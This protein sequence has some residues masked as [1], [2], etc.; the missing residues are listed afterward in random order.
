M[1]AK[2]SKGKGFRGVLNYAMEKDS[3]ILDSN[4]AGQTPRALAAEFGEVRKLRPSLGNAV[5]HTALSAPVGEQISDDL[6]REIGQTFMEKMGYT[7]NQYIMV[8]HKD[9]DHQHV[10][11]I[12]NRITHTGDVVSDA[13]DYKRLNKAMREIEVEYELTQV[14]SIAA[15]RKAPTK[16]EI[17]RSIRTG[18]PSTRQ[19]LQQLASACAKDCGNYTEYA[20]RLEAVGVE[21]IPYTQMNDTKLNGLMYRLDGV[22]MKGSDLGKAYSPS[23]LAKQGVTYDK[24]RDIAAIQRASEREAHRAAQDQDHRLEKSPTPERGGTGGLDRP[25]GVSP[26]P[27][28]GGGLRVHPAERSEHPAHRAADGNDTEPSPASRG[29]DTESRK[30]HH[31]ESGRDSSRDWT[32]HSASYQRIVRLGRSQPPTRANQSQRAGRSDLSRTSDTERENRTAAQQQ[33]A[34]IK[35]P[36]IAAIPTKKRRGKGYSATVQQ[37]DLKPHW[38]ALQRQN[39]LGAPVQLEIRQSNHIVVENLDAKAIA[40]MTQDGLP[41]LS[42]T[43]KNGS[44]T[45]LIRI[46]DY[47]NVPRQWQTLIGDHIQKTYGG[48]A[49]VEANIPLAGFDGVKL[50]STTD[51]TAPRGLVILK[52]LARQQHEHE[53]AQTLAQEKTHRWGV[54]EKTIHAGTV[55]GAE[56]E[57]IKLAGKLH[58]KR[59]DG[60]QATQIDTNIAK[61]LL[62]EGFDGKD[63]AAAIEKRSPN[64]EAIGNSPQ[65]AQNRVEQALG[66]REVQNHIKEQER[67]KIERQSKPD[68][69]SRFER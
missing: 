9:T 60:D 63:I 66:S 49:K 41:A 53:K 36:T 11:I 14:A 56:R 16:G 13:N 51:T 26:S 3:E 4:M 46:N 65:Y 58:D 68:R 28:D 5:V 67:A 6:W 17:E 62:L 29:R 2:T 23:G 43:Q 54:V 69:G 1:I 27:V 22:A 25:T 10:H 47:D 61:T 35:N 31:P 7:D 18:E 8:K 64:I 59:Y 12:A 38:A 39:A 15:E 40:R 30:P 55:Y 20:Q 34:V 44:H 45:A 42:V 37:G 57:Y 19:Q 21:L 33:L 48:R 50:V 32:D 24:D 52:D